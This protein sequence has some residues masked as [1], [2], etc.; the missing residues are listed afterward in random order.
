VV[1]TAFLAFLI[2][3]IAGLRTM[4]APAAVSWAACLGRLDLSATPF[5]WLGHQYALWI[6]TILALGELVTDQLPTTP[7]RKL[8]GPFIARIVAGAL[9][10]GAIAA[11]AAM[12]FA[13]VVAGASGA[14]VGTVGGYAARAALARSFGRDWPAALVE[15]AV[16]IGGAALI[17]GLL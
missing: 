15:D 1:T 11:P 4:M 14:V 10:G 13:G 17:V 8:P 7:S 3:I 9:A 12:A 2:G 6:L 16:A 5:S